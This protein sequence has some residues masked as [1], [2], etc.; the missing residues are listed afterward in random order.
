MKRLIVA[1]AF[2][3]ALIWPASVIAALPSWNLAGSYTLEFTCTSADCLGTTYV[4]SMTITSS[5]HVTGAVA[6]T[7]SI[8]GQPT[9][10]WTV[11]GTV[12]GSDVTLEILW[13]AGS[14][15]TE[16]NPLDADGDHRRDGRDVGHR[17]RW[18]D[19]HLRLGDDVGSGDRHRPHQAHGHGHPARHADQR[20]DPRLHR[21]LQRVGQRA[22]R[23]RLRPHRHRDRLHGR[24]AVRLGCLLHRRRHRL[25][26]GHGHP[27][28]QGRQRRGHGRQRRPGGRRRG[29]DRDHRPHQAH[30]HGHPA[31]HADQRGDPR[32]HRHLQRVGHRAHRRRLR[33]HRHRDRLHGRRAVRLGCLLHRRRHRLLRGHGHPGPQGRHGVRRRGQRRPGGRRRGLDRDHRP[34]QAHGHGHPAR[35]ADQRGDPRLHRHL[36]RVGQRAHRRRLRPHRHRDRLHGRRAVRLGCLLHRRRHRLLRGHGHPGPQG[37]HGVRRR[38][39]RR[40]GGRRRGLDRDDRPHQAHGH[41]HPARH[42]DQRGDP[43][44][45]R[46]L[47]RVG[48]RAHRRRLRPHRHRDRLHGRRAVR[49]GCL[50]HRRRHRLLRGHGHPGPQGRQRRGHGRATPARR[51][52]SRPRP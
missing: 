41:G 46:H 29:L 44:L 7:G 30:G 22:H 27:G 43:R 21:H 18:G 51:P 24:R 35:H 49:L 28:P 13:S 36:Q 3:M 45:H 6:G 39:Q 34:H 19:A 48:Q 38:G 20:G 26:R 31:R 17:G 9:Y 32:L 40:P 42:A 15:L 1:A 2:L 10:D 23:R 5:N 47:Q 33:P 4:H 16:Y 37:R 11:T 52:T 14:G 50:L 8:E 25:L 12:S